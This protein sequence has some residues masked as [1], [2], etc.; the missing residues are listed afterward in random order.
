MEHHDPAEELLLADAAELCGCSTKTLKRDGKDPNVPLNVVSRDGRN[1]VT[2]GDLIA[3][4][5][6]KPGTESPS[7]QA[8]RT[9]LERRIAGLET[10][11]TQLRAERAHEAALRAQA[12]R[13]IKTLEKSLDSALKGRA[14]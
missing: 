12:D 14:A 9:E 7:A 5:R 11:L 1:Y 4:G 13:F 10:D 2:V 8:T 3:A 6:Y